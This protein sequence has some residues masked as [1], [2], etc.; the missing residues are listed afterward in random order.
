MAH[1]DRRPRG[2]TLV[3]VMVALVVS[4]MVLLGVRALFENLSAAQ[5]R[6]VTRE[7]R[8]NAAANGMRLLRA[9][10]GR[11]DVGNPQSVPFTG[12][13]DSS[14]FSSWCE[15]PGGWLERCTVMLAFDTSGSLH[16]L[17]A[18][19]DGASRLVL[20][21]GFR[22]G[23]IRYLSDPAGGGHWLSEWGT[24]ITAPLAIGVILD[25]DT[26]IV[27]VGERG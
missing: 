13:P 18:R 9:L 24:G 22:T 14:R 5:R 25:R 3:E 20:V 6:I 17:V 4:G 21:R 27:R 1:G 19:F 11:L 10:V 23:T 26:L 8:A 16:T 12:T 2:F 7:V 15:V